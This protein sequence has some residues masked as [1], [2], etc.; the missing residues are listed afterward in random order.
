MFVSLLMADAKAPG[1]AIR[2]RIHMRV[3]LLARITDR[4][5]TL[6]TIYSWRLA[7]LSA[8]VA[9]SAFALNAAACRRKRA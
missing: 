1:Y 7:V 3:M 4:G 8:S 5:I 6:K 2:S 9:F